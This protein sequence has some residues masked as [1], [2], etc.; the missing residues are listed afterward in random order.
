M[1]S[2]V[3]SQLGQLDVLCDHYLSKVS[4]N[5][6]CGK[7]M[8]ERPRLPWLGVDAYLSAWDDGS[9]CLARLLP[10][11][12][13]VDGCI[14]DWGLS[15]WWKISRQGTVDNHGSMRDRTV[16]LFMCLEEREGFTVA[17]LTSSTTRQP[18]RRHVRFLFRSWWTDQ[19]AG[20]D[21]MRPGISC[22]GSGKGAAGLWG[23]GQLDRPSPST[24]PIT[25]AAAWSCTS[26][27]MRDDAM[28]PAPKSRRSRMGHLQW[29]HCS[30]AIDHKATEN[31]AS[32][33]ERPD[34]G[35]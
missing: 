15:R 23:G 20:V 7:T 30:A 22:W 1:P 32:K 6:R 2:S 18:Q 19:P 10:N 8:E 29:H 28:T 34:T 17:N 3:L 31:T 26:T 25:R 35:R 13:S 11:L 9:R 33:D 5:S 24:T 27:R 16:I 12:V 21:T 4:L 14:V